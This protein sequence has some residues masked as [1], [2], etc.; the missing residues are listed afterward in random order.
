[1][2]IMETK[3]FGTLQTWVTTSYLGADLGLVTSGLLSLGALSVPQ[4]H[5]Y[6]SQRSWKDL[7][8]TVYVRSLA[9]C[10]IIP[11]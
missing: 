10:F 7:N 1:M 9:D 2:R 6:L 11:A 5:D 3:C 4:V 8:G